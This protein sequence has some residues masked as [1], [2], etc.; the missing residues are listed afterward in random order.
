MQSKKFQ[1]WEG[2][3]TAIQVFCVAPTV[4]ILNKKRIASMLITIVHVYGSNL[5]VNQ[6]YNAVYGTVGGLIGLIFLVHWGKISF[7]SP[8]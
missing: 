2:S 3:I 1:I 8:A 7:D 4:Y 6:Y 5:G